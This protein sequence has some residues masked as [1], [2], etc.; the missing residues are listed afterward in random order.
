MTAQLAPLFSAKKGS[1][2]LLKTSASGRDL[3][4]KVYR[5]KPRTFKFFKYRALALFGLTI[6]IE[7]RNEAQR[8]SFEQMVYTRWQECGYAVPQL[9]ES[10]ELSALVGA[11][12][13]HIILEY[14]SG[15]T[16]EAFLRDAARPTSEKLEILDRLFR[17]SRQRHEQCFKD[18]D[19]R[20]V[21]FDSN[22]RNIIVR[23]GALVSFDFEM[24][25]SNEPLIRSVAREIQKVAVEAAN[26]LGRSFLDRIAATI[27]HEYRGTG[28]KMSIINDALPQDKRSPANDNSLESRVT[29]FDLARA[30]ARSGEMT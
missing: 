5:P 14:I 2:L 20:L 22:L 28:I 9:H 30:L 27:S 3:I 25:R 17:E 21:H 11:G 7:Y 10:P 13:V 19:Y 24:G 8:K 29:R 26:V 1:N 23:D 4:I 16:L 6:P 18:Q 12:T 15:P